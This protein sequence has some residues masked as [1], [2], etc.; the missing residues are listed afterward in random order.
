MRLRVWLPL[1]GDLHNQGLNNV[2]VTNNGATV[3]TSGK[4]GSCYSF[5]GTDDY[6][7]LTSSIL[8]DVIKGGTIPFSIAMWV[9]HA[10]ATRGVL[11]GDYNLSGAIKFNIELTTNHNVR[12]YWGGSPDLTTDIIVANA[13]WSHIVITYDGTKIIGYLNGSAVE[14]ITNFELKKAL[15]YLGIYFNI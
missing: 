11:F 8:Y 5:D 1:N 13:E 7:S 15:I 14:S 12:F 3:N 6:I 4:I 9:Y 10:D 2:I